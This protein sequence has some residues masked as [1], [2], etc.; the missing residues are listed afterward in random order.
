MKEKVEWWK[1]ITSC[2]LIAAMLCCSPIESL[3]QASVNKAKVLEYGTQVVLRINE[4]FKGSSNTDNGMITSTVAADVYSA[5]GTEVLIKA[6]TPAVIEYTAESNGICGKPGRICL[7]HATTR[8][9]DNKSVS[10]GMT[11]CKKGGGKLGG[12]IALSVLFFPIGL[13]S[14]C[15][16]GSMPNLQ[17]GATFTGLVMQDVAVE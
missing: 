15:M 8:T 11:S 2:L 10:L 4:N 5:D 9:V 12:V 16:K 6:G 3:A 13:I 1:R 14:L 17:Q 7:T